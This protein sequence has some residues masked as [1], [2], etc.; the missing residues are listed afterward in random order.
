V[1]DKDYFNRQRISATGRIGIGHFT[2]FGTYQLTPLFKEGVAAAIRPYTVG[3]TI[4]GL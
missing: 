1:F 4:S 3:L 2:V